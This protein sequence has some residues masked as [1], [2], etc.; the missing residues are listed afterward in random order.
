MWA[1][2]DANAA[3]AK[4][5]SAVFTGQVIEVLS[6]EMMKIYNPEKKTE[7]RYYLSGV[8]GLR[9]IPLTG[10]NRDLHE[11][12]AAVR[13]LGVEFMCERLV[14]KQCKVHLDFVKNVSVFPGL[15]PPPSNEATGELYFVTVMDENRQNVAVEGVRAG[16][17]TVAPPAATEDKTAAYVQLCEAEAAAKAAGAGMHASAGGSGKPGKLL[18]RQRFFE[19]FL[20]PNDSK[21]GTSTSNTDATGGNTCPATKKELVDRCKGYAETLGKQK[22]VAGHVVHVITGSRLRI[23]VPS[24]KIILTFSLKDVRAPQPQFPQQPGQP[25][26]DAALARTRHLTLQQSVKFT[27]DRVD[28]GGTFHGELT[29][30]PGG[31]NLTHT[32]LSEGLAYCDQ[33]CQNAK[34]LELEKEQKAL[35]TGL[36]AAYQEPVAEQKL[37]PS[38]KAR[39]THAESLDSMFFVPLNAHTDKVLAEVKAVGAEQASKPAVDRLVKNHLYLARYEGVWYRFKFWKKERGVIRGHYIDQ[40]YLDE[41]DAEDLRRLPP[42]HR[43]ENTRPLAREL[44]LY[45]VKTN[46]EHARDAL[47]LLYAT[48][49]PHDQICTVNV[50][51]G[52]Q[53]RVTATL[54]SGDSLQEVLLR[55][56]LARLYPK[57]PLKGP[58]QL[59]CRAAEEKARDT[60]SNMWQF[61]DCGFSDDEDM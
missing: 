27:V 49:S 3:S 23:K 32:L 52:A 37:E 9:Q 19:L 53:F 44:G 30:C 57:E 39:L 20:H 7:M 15:K 4:S 36:W 40:G 50:V 17:L 54:P 6:A 10:E 58:L 2:S 60:R 61:G 26:G 8:R 34:Y 29:T 13:A 33:Y 55:E 45:G 1:A 16:V 56:G 21:S 31:V 14:G 38:F 28:L 48:T 51:D 47:A 46:K 12:H 18:Q 25:C 42:N 11:H 22:S 41:A 43:L 24:E 5:S 59:S 35:N